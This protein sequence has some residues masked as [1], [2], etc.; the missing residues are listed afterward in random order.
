MVTRV[1]ERDQLREAGGNCQRG[2]HDECMFPADCPCY[3]HG[4]AGADPRAELVALADRL[5][6]DL[7]AEILRL[8]GV[9]HLHTVLERNAQELARRNNELTV[10][11]GELRQRAARA[12][13]RLEDLGVE[14]YSKARRAA[15][16]LGDGYLRVTSHGRGHFETEH[17][18]TE[19]VTLRA[20]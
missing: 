13:A 3:C 6:P 11:V 19:R 15:L 5:R 9:E 12:E 4:P 18:P 17:I 7:A 2:A 8:Y 10:I 14:E 1:P 20:D 16:F